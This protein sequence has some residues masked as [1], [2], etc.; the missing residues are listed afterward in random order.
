MAQLEKILA[1]IIDRE[2]YVSQ[3]VLAAA[4]KDI[5][6]QYYIDINYSIEEKKKYFDYF[7]F[8]PVM[9]IGKLGEYF[10]CGLLLIFGAVGILWKIVQIRKEEA[11]VRQQETV[12]KNG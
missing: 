11:Q 7:V 12:D 1:D 4:Q 2:A 8:L 6:H 10:Y 5:Y 3:G 9:F